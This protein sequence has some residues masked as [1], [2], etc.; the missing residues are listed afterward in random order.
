MAGESAHRARPPAVCIGDVLSVE[1][2]C[3]RLTLSTVSKLTLLGG[4][5]L[6]IVAPAALGLRFR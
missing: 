5:M 1:I 6:V 2:Y 4:V 3:G